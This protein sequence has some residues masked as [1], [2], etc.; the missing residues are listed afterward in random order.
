MGFERKCLDHV[1]FD[2]AVKHEQ[3]IEPW[4][5][6]GTMW[7]DNVSE[8]VASTIQHSIINFCTPGTTV[9]KSEMATKPYRYDM[10][11]NLVTW[12]FDLGEKS[13]IAQDEPI[14]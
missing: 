7:C 12:A 8:D 6:Y 10:E 4:F 3:K 13:T 11:D 5:Q 14:E 1:K 9:S 2:V